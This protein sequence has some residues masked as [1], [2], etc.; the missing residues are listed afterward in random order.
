MNIFF[1]LLNSCYKPIQP[2]IILYAIQLK[3]IIQYQ[4]HATQIKIMAINSIISRKRIL[5]MQVLLK[6]KVV[7]HHM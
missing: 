5:F 1:L 6:T 3:V 7:G 4:L 2:L